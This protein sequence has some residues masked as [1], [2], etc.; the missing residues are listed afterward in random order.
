M[1]PEYKATLVH[2]IADIGESH[3]NACATHSD[4]IY[5]PF[6]DHRFLKALEESGSVSA[7]TGWAPCHLLLQ[8]EGDAVHG[9]VPMYLKNHSQGEYVF[10]H[11][12]AHAFEHAGGNYY[13]K[14]Q[15]S[16]PFTPA[17]GPKLLTTPG[18]NKASSEA[19]LIIACKEAAKSL[20]VSSL[21]LTFLPKEQSH[22]LCDLGFLQRTDQQFHW[23]NNH[24]R[25]FDDFLE[26]LTSRKRKNLRK[27]RLAAYESE[28]EI[29]HVTGSDLT[30][31][32]WDAFFE[33]YMDTGSRKWGT[34]Y[35]TRTFFSL[36]NETMSEHTLLIM[37]KRDGQYIAGALNFI[38]GD[39][40]FGRNWGA[41][42]NHRFLHFEACY[43]QAIDFAIAR[44]LKRVEAGA[45]GMHKLARGYLP[46]KTY[47]A[48]WIADPN[49]RDAVERYLEDERRHVDHEINALDNHTPFR[50]NVDEGIKHDDL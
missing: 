48:H 13:P 24:Y 12:W 40:L 18:A 26:S 37:C 20:K 31:A 29:E 8:D 11:N 1:L 21:H 30:E 36:I 25:S 7:E 23:Q 35:L 33:F 42:E 3:W 28:I 22:A 47:S 6:V 45:Q 14:L 43:Y 41:I 9:V 50:K 15:S 46:H 39:T 32:H 5:N 10:D 2:R 27:E 4:V 49:F 44:G 34:P 38:G 17:T 16:I 19:A